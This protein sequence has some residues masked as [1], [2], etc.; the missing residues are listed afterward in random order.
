MWTMQLCTIPARFLLRCSI[1]TSHNKE[2]D[3]S[4]TGRECKIAF[5]AIVESVNSILSMLICSCQY[6]HA[7][8]TQHDMLFSLQKIIHPLSIQPEKPTNYIN[9]LSLVHPFLVHTFKKDGPKASEACFT[10]AS[11]ESCKAPRMCFAVRCLAS[12]GSSRALSNSACLLTA[13]GCVTMCS[14]SLSK[15]TVGLKGN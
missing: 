8:Q 12:D 6:G 14:N 11:K 3:T 9:E 1:S 4:K 13:T 15:A 10:K 5:Q 2:T 7:H